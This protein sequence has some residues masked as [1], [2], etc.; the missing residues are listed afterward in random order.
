V[1]SFDVDQNQPAPLSS[2]GRQ[3]TFINGHLKRP[4]PASPYHEYFT[5]VDAGA[6]KGG[7]ANLCRESGEFDP[8]RC[9]GRVVAIRDCKDKPE[10]KILRV[11]SID[12][13]RSATFSASA[14]P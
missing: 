3:R 2:F 11:F 13:P 9:R 7:I 14:E 5:I 10:N 4:D 12:K 1:Y 8:P 6:D